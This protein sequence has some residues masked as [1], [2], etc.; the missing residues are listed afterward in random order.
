MET[1]VKTLYSRREA[2]AALAVS[3]STLDVMIARGMLRAVRFG[4]RVLIHRDEIER[5]GRKIAQGDLA[6]VWQKLDGK[7]RR[8]VAGAG[9][10]RNGPEVRKENG[11]GY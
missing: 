10:A 1:A 2:A 11:L 4:R 8:I 3:V 7:T 9:I 5:C 6:G